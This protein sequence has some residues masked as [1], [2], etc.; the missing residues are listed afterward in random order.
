MSTHADA[1]DRQTDAL[2]VLIFSH[3]SAH[4]LL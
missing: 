3:P 4:D 2:I 1:V